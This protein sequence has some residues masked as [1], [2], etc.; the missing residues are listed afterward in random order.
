MDKQIK[1][2]DRLVIDVPIKTVSEANMRQHW[3]AKHKRRTA[4][5]K[6][7]SAIWKMRRGW[8]PIPLPC[9][10]TFTRIGP[11]MLDDDNLR[12]AFKHIRDEVARL[13]KTDDS[14]TGQVEWNYKQEA[15]GK[16]EYSIRIEVQSLA[17]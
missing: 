12:G 6:A 11:K 4:Q 2:T 10:V 13:L 8:H 3:A 1:I 15:I 9:R 5:Q 14:V 7:V 17:G 16:R